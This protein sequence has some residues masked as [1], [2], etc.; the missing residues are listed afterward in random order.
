[1]TTVADLRANAFLDLESLA[2][3][4]ERILAPPAASDSDDDLCKDMLASAG[5]RCLEEQ[6]HDLTLPQTNERTN[7]SLHA[8]VV[9]LVMQTE[10]CYVG[11]HQQIETLNSWPVV[12]CRVAVLLPH[13]FTS[14]WMGS[15]KWLPYLTQGW[16]LIVLLGCTK[17]QVNKDKSGIF[18]IDVR[19]VVNGTQ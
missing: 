15:D 3:R 18:N 13:P 12:S 8:L 14:D 9:D 10:I 7:S 11:D 6:P 5:W 2:I 4:T 19:K 16:I 1:V 17:T